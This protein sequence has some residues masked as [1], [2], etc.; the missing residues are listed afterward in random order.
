MIKGAYLQKVSEIK[1]VFL[2]TRN[3]FLSFAHFIKHTN[4]QRNA[5]SFSLC[6]GDQQGS[7]ELPEQTPVR[8][9][10]ATEFTGDDV[11]S[12]SNPVFGVA[13]PL[14]VKPPPS[15]F[16]PFFSPQ[17]FRIIGGSL[18]QKQ[19]VSPLE[20]SESSDSPLEAAG[21]DTPSVSVCLRRASAGSGSLSSSALAAEASECPRLE[22]KTSCGLAAGTRESIRR[23][24]S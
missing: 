1:S 2:N 3:N 12:L 18:M 15:C 16:F 10:R 20:E 14:G 23:P 9:V 13:L 11:A 21:R 7:C 4:V 5:S 22:T 24:D 19:S 6:A 17:W 8:P